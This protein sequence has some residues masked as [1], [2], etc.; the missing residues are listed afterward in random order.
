MLKRRWLF[1]LLL[2]LLLPILA[3]CGGEEA[4]TAPTAAT[5]GAATTAPATGAATTAPA[6][7]AATTAPTTGGAT[8]GDYNY[9]ALPVEDGATLTLVASGNP[10]EQKI[11]QDSIDR[12]NKV[13]P[14]IKV[15]FEAVAADYPVKIKADAAGD[16][17]GDVFFIDSGLFNALAPNDILL[18]LDPY[19][20]QIGMKPADF[21]GPLITIFQLEGKTY[22]LPK[23]FGGLA[24]HINNRLAQEAGVTIPADGNWTWDDFKA[25][26]QKMTKGDGNAKIFGT[27]TPPDI[28]RAGAFV[29]ANG[30]KVLSDD[31]KSAEYNQPAAVEA[32]TWWHGLYKDGLGA[33]PKEI[34]QDW[35]GAAFGNEKTAMVVEGGW[36]FNYMKQSFPT[37]EY[38]TVPMPKAPKT[39]ERATLLFTNAWAANAKTKFPNAAA[40]LITFLVGKSNQQTIAETGFAV[41]SLAALA[42]LP[43]Y[44]TDTKSGVIA[45]SAEYGKLAV[46]GPKNDDFRKPL[47][48]A[49]EKIWL[50]GAD[51]QATLDEAAKLSTEALK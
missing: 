18:E 30:G 16:T 26:A 12:F 25:A 40:A 46:Y 13:F 21:A 11:Y 2:V 24:V 29:F 9:T 36:M 3:A 8:T 48:D 22:G 50:S 23:D 4:T 19:M 42:D 20:S 49:M 1:S 33:V 17:L 15:T 41:S 37:I 34:G 32:I 6:T 45:K 5:G 31:G 28:D 51:I 35:C 14:D 7:G 43:Y 38:T 44:K 47:L 27:C 39:G 10:E